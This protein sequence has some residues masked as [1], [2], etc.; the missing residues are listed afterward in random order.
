[1]FPF[2]LVGL[3]RSSFQ[4]IQVEFPRETNTRLV[5]ETDRIKRQSKASLLPQ[6]SQSTWSVTWRFH[7]RRCQRPSNAACRYHPARN[8]SSWESGSKPG[9]MFKATLD[10]C[11]EQVCHIMVPAAEIHGRE[12]HRINDF[13][14]FFGCSPNA[15]QVAPRCGIPL[16]STCN[17]TFATNLALGPRRLVPPAAEVDVGFVHGFEQNVVAG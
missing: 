3:T 2:Y 5:G 14:A 6:K 16:Y 10:C 1:M 8:L 9:S 12:F 13:S 17:G 4:Q 7:G 15:N 11:F